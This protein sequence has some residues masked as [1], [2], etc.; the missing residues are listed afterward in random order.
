LESSAGE[1]LDRLARLFASDAILASQF[2]GLRRSPLGDPGIRRLLLA[3][4]ADALDCARASSAAHPQSVRGRR[5]DEARA[6]LLDAARTA[7]FS[8]IW[9]CDGLGIDPAYLRRRLALAVGVGWA[10]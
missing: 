5:R 8:F 6:W 3:V 1:A 2:N 7:P 4:L 10:S 9:V